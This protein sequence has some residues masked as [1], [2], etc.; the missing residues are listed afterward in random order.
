MP[1]ADP[2]HPALLPAA[3][4]A[5]WAATHQLPSA[6]FDAA[7]RAW[8]SDDALWVVSHPV[9]TLVGPS[10]VAAGYF[11][12]LLAAL[13]DIERRTDLFFGGHWDGHI[14]GG[15]GCWVT[16]I[17]HY[18]GTLRAPLWGIPACGQPVWLRFGEFYRIEHGRIAEA[19]ILLDLVDLARQAGCP[20]LPPSPGRDIL[21]PGPRAQDGLQRGSADPVLSQQSFD[22]VMAMIGGLGRYDQADLNSMGMTRYWHP[23]MMWYGPCGIGTTRS[24]TGFE[25]HHQK[26][27]L[28][29]LPDR[30]G[31]HHRVR[32]GDGPYVATTGWPSVRATHNGPYLGVPASGRPVQMRVMDWWRADAGLLVENWVLLDLPHFFLQLDVDILARAAT[33]GWQPTA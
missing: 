8:L 6:G 15:A 7:C 20:V 3:K 29:A 31:G 5:A 11:A 18:V 23:D 4:A 19:R 14:D 30:K 17:G 13:P 2:H 32:L 10:A 1:A 27:F 28:T 16:C 26:P 21:V 12:P 33:G 22:L 9:N 25:Q 24:I